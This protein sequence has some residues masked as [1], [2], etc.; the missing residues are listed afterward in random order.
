MK[1]LREQIV[2]AQFVH[3][4]I[5]GHLGTVTCDCTTFI[6]DGNLKLKNHNEIKNLTRKQIMEDGLP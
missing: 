4:Y 1:H 6:I 2:I 3:V 5:A